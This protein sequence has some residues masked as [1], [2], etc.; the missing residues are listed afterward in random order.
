MIV[1]VDEF[2]GAPRSCLVMKEGGF[3]EEGADK[4][5]VMVGEG[6]REGGDDTTEYFEGFCLDRKKI[7]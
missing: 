1:G 3:M 5:V 4:V 2:L 6:G 7:D